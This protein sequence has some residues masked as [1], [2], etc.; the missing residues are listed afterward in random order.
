MNLTPESVLEV[1]G[2]LHPLVLHAPIGLFTA[3]G[4]IEGWRLLS[5]DPK[6][7]HAPPILAVMAGLSALTTAVFGL[8][9]AR[10]SAYVSFTVQLHQWLGVA[11][12]LCALVCTGLLLRV[13]AFNGTSPTGAGLGSRRLAYFIALGLTLGLMVPTGHFGGDLSHGEGFITE[14]LTRSVKARTPRQ[15]QAGEVATGT[16]AVAK[17]D[18]IPP[19]VQRV[20]DTTCISCHG[21]AKEKGGLRLDTSA[22]LWAGGD[23]GQIVVRGKPEES[24]LIYRLTVALDHDDHMP[25]KGKP[26]PEAAEIEVVSAWIAG[27]KPSL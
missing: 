25:P 23:G 20:F 15:G 24:E 10:E 1:L 16:I 13:H 26:Q 14:P 3:I 22:G 27:L 8:I 6:A 9:L 19:D 12:A 2:R 5:R 7:P 4:G 18:E 17:G 21:R 11:F